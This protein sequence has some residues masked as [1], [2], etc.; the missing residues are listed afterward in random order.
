MRAG[1][2]FR[3]VFPEGLHLQPA[4]KKLYFPLQTERL[5]FFHRATYAY[6][7][8]RK[9]AACI[10]ACPARPVRF[11]PAS[12]VVGDP[13]V[14]STVSATQKICKPWLFA[15]LAQFSPP[16]GIV[17]EIQFF[18]VYPANKATIF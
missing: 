17:N 16:C 7:P 3:T 1:L 15:L 11:K 5:G 13:A 18:Y 2:F 14:Q 6:K 10:P 4:R 12:D 9:T 8:N